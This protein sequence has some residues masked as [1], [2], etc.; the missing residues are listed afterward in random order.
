MGIL[1]RQ[2]QTIIKC[3]VENLEMK[4]A[5]S[6][7]KNS[8]N[9]LSADCTQKREK[10]VNFK[11]HRKKSHKLKQKGKRVRKEHPKAVGKY[12]MTQ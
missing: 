3:Q 7:V 4:N 1:C 12:K 11:I 2:M 9:E 10:L 6:E 5:M 8:F